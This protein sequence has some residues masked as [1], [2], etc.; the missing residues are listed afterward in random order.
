MAP[1]PQQL[2]FD[3]VNDVNLVDNDQLR[4]KVSLYERQSRWWDLESLVEAFPAYS[5]AILM[6]IYVLYMSFKNS[7]GRGFRLRNPSGCVRDCSS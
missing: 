1:E 4:V 3:R 5:E 7:F 6:L 2:P